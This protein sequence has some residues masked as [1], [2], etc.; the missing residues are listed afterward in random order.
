MKLLYC[1]DCQDV[2]KIINEMSRTCR[3]GASTGVLDDDELTATVTGPC[4]VLGLGSRSVRQAALTQTQE[5]D[6]GLRKMVNPAVK[7]LN[8]DRKEDPDLAM[9]M[10]MMLP[11]SA[12]RGALKG[13]KVEA[14]VI[15]YKAETVV[16]KSMPP[17]DY[18]PASRTPYDGKKRVECEH[19][20]QLD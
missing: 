13:R 3:C 10:A 9:M 15:P 20:Q 12:Y 16:R 1:L 5:G 14:F 11:T 4:Q 17:R 18:N 7:K 6:T 2:L 19:E 8:Q